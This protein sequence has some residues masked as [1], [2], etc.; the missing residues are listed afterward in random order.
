MCNDIVTSVCSELQET[1]SR[2]LLLPFLPSLITLLAAMTTDSPDIVLLVVIDTLQLVAQ[3]S[4]LAVHS[5]HCQ[6]NILQ[7]NDQIT[8]QQ[9][10]PLTD[11]AMTLFLKYSHGKEIH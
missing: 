7:M 3:V 8:A 5:I 4:S 1:E 2:E 6:Q 10:Q 9:A 11:V